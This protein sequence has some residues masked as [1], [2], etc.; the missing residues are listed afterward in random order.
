MYIIYE[1]IKE[2]IET[3]TLTLKNDKVGRF[4]M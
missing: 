3:N 2:Y 4:L 1:L